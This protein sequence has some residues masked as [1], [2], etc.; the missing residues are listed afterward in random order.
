L[1]CEV[2][3]YFSE[4]KQLLIKAFFAGNFSVT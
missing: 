3:R 4:R 2:K 1:R